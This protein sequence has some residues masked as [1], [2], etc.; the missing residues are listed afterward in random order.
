[1]YKVTLNVCLTRRYLPCASLD[2]DLCPSRLITKVEVLEKS[3]QIYLQ[4]DNLYYYYYYYYYY[5][6]SHN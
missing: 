6:V 4:G 5:L 2:E 1:M 3:H